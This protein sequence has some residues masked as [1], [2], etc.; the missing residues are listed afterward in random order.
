MRWESVTFD[1][2]HVRAFL[3]TV[4]EGSFS[5]AARALNTTQPTIGRRVAELETALGVTLV[6]R[7]ARGPSLTDAGT[8][9][10]H[11]VRAMAEAAALISMAAESHSIDVAGEVAITA[12]DLMS[13]TMLPRILLPLRESHS[14]L[15]LRIIS[16]NGVQGLLRRE[17]DIA[18]RHSR[19]TEPEL[20]A[21]HIGVLHANLYATSSYLDQ[22]GRPR[23]PRDLADHAFLGNPHPTLLLAPLQDRGV[24]LRAENFAVTSD[25]SVVVWEHVKAGYGVS[26]LPEVLCADDPNLEQVL[27][28]LPP[29]E[30][31]VW[32]VAHR[33][34]HTSKRIRVVF[35]RLARGLSE[36]AKT[37]IDS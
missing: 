28:G 37:E 4:E 7:S 19:P 6:S 26:M 22:A 18:V 33:E 1:W 10:L 20:Y 3:A 14:R 16:T 23:A 30:V 12:T 15:R 13:A 5:A 31:P 11:H 21:R 9:L 27:P 24:P 8:D 29:L 32:L 25:N 17:A 34:L 36:L 35:D 2:N